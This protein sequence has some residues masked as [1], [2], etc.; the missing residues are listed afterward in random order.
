MIEPAEPPFDLPSGLIWERVTFA[1]VADF[2]I[3]TAQQMLERGF[4]MPYRYLA[5]L[6]MRD[7]TMAHLCIDEQAE[8][9]SLLAELRPLLH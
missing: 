3:V 6:W 7:G 5:L 2:A 9:D 8:L 4:P 1:N